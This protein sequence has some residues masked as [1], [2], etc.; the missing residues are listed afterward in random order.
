MLVYSLHLYLP[1]RVTRASLNM[2]KVLLVAILFLNLGFAHSGYNQVFKDK[3]LGDYQISVFEDTHLQDGQ[4]QLSLFMQVTKNGQAP[5]EDLKLELAL[6]QNETVIRKEAQALGIASNDG[7]VIYNAY[8]LESILPALGH[9]DV[10]LDI[11]A[12]TEVQSYTFWLNAEPQRQARASEFIPSLIIISIALAGFLMLFIN[13]QTVQR[14]D[15]PHAKQTQLS[16][17]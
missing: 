4:P 9:Y 13:P 17:L 2:P 15:L 11:Q 14:K 1:T 6:S 16:H 5:Q 12:A 8:L 7:R 10:Q 3:T